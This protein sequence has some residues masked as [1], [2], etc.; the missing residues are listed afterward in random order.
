MPGFLFGSAVNVCSDL[1]YFIYRLAS[2]AFVDP[3]SRCCFFPPISSYVKIVTYLLKYLDC[4][5]NVCVISH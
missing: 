3:I 4:N 5:A 2:I 1:G